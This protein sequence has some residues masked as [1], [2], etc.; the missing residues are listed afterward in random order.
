MLQITFEGAAQR[1]QASVRKLK[2]PINQ[3]HRI[4]C[5]PRYKCVKFHVQAQ[6]QTRVII[7]LC[8]AHSVTMQIYF[9]VCVKGLICKRLSRLNI[10]MHLRLLKLHMAQSLTTNVS[11]DPDCQISVLSCGPDRPKK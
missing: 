10:V 4:I 1:Q 9:Y 7:T 11:R 6:Q 5:T 2:Q 8:M 3:K